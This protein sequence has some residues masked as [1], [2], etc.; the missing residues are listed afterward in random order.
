MGEAVNS[1]WCLSGYHHTCPR[2]L[3]T[4]ECHKKK[5]ATHD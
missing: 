1:G 5:E 4:C 3:C 2:P